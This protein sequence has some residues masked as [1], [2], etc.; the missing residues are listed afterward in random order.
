MTGNLWTVT[1]TDIKG[2]VHSIV[3]NARTHITHI[4]IKIMVHFLYPRKF[5]HASSQCLAL[6]H[7]HQKQVVICFLSFG[8]YITIL[9]NMW[10][11]MQRNVIFNS[12]KYTFL[13]WKGNQEIFLN[14][15]G[16][17]NCSHS[18]WYEPTLC[19]CEHTVFICDHSVHTVLHSAFCDFNTDSST[20]QQVLCHNL[21]RFSNIMV[22]SLCHIQFGVIVDYFAKIAF[23]YISDCAEYFF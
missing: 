9:F 10:V 8:F 22:L 6:S 19:T 18:A 17:D 20:F 4:L 1:C 5:A 21:L 23:M 7:L 2:R 3:T 14:L 11:F 13:K 12:K 15:K 16:E